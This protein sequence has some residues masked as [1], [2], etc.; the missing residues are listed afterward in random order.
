MYARMKRFLQTSTCVDY[1][2]IIMRLINISLNYFLAFFIYL[3]FFLTFYRFF[4]SPSPIMQS[5]LHN[6]R[7]NDLFQLHFIST[8]WK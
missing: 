7:T 1:N 8:K 4:P 2:D 6:N 5:F 3:F